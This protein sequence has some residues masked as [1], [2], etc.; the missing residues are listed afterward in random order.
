MVA[1]LRGAVTSGSLRGYSFVVWLV[2]VA[3]IELLGASTE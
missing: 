3:S 1:E 2:G